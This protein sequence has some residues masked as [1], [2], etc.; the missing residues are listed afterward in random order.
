MRTAIGMLIWLSVPNSIF[1]R[2]PTAA[3]NIFPTK[4]P[5][6][7]QRATQRLKYRS[8]RLRRFFSI[9][10]SPFIRLYGGY[11]PHDVVMGH[12]S[13]SYNDRLYSP[14]FLNGG[15]GRRW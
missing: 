2:A 6:P 11:H 13:F 10:V 9:S 14:G 7:M 1:L 4:M 5:N 8:K 3:G 12:S 15:A